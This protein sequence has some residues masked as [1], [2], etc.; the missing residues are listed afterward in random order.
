MFCTYFRTLTQCLKLLEDYMSETSNTEH[1]WS[2]TIDTS[3]FPTSNIWGSNGTFRRTIGKNLEF[4][5]TLDSLADQYNSDLQESFSKNGRD[6]DISSDEDR[7]NFDV[8]ISQPKSQRSNSLT[9]PTTNFISSS[10]ENL[11]EEPFLQKPRSFS[12]SSEHSLGHLRPIGAFGTTGSETRLDALRNH[13]GLE[14]GMCMV[15]PW[16]KSLRL[17][18]YIWL[19]SNITYNQMMSIDEEYLEKLGKIYIY[20]WF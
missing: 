8:T 20:L 15:G 17:H 12:L 9:P 14:P 4:R 3:I 5:N 7:I 6:V 16:L 18:K 13:N 11:N 19:F 10:S 1:I 2:Q